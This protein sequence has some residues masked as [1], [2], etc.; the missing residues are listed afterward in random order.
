MRAKSTTPPDQ[1]SALFKHYMR[2]YMAQPSEAEAN[3]VKAVQH[4]VSAGGTE[5]ITNRKAL[6]HVMA[7]HLTIWPAGSGN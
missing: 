3:A 1:L 5:W 6:A 7:T 2:A 4:S